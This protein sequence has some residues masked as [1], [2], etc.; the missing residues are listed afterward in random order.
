MLR[1]R[2]RRKNHLGIV[3]IRLLEQC[4][5]IF[6]GYPAYMHLLLPSD[7][8]PATHLPHLRIPLP[9]DVPRLKAYRPSPSSANSSSSISS[10]AS[11]IFSETSGKPLATTFP[12]LRS[13]ASCSS[14]STS[15]S[16][17]P[18]PSSSNHRQQTIPAEGGAEWR[19]VTYT[20]Q[21]Q[22]GRHVLCIEEQAWDFIGPEE[23]SQSQSDTSDSGMGFGVE[24]ERSQTRSSQKSKSGKSVKGGKKMRSPVELTPEESILFGAFTGGGMMANRL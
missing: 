13:P 21:E 14:I 2:Y 11:T 8:T 10:S 18:S 9:T 15:P 7:S 3:K 16:P 20:R 12:N 1:I 24:L 4:A 22:R 5:L 23:V 17:S 6:F 19:L